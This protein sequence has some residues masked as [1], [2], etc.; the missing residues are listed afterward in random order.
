MQKIACV[1]IALAAAAGAQTFPDGAAYRNI[2]A[3]GSIVPGDAAVFTDPS[4]R[5]VRSQSLTNGNVAGGPSYAT[6]GWV[7]G[8]VAPVAAAVAAETAARAAADDALAE[9][10]AQS[11]AA[12]AAARAAGDADKATTNQLAAAVAGVP[13]GIL[14]LD[15]IGMPPE[16]W[17]AGAVW[18]MAGSSNGMAVVSASLEDLSGRTAYDLWIT[19]AYEGGTVRAR[20]LCRVNTAD[21]SYAHSGESF[22]VDPALIYGEIGAETV[23]V[24]TAVDGKLRITPLNSETPA[25]QISGLYLLVFPGQ[26]YP[27][28]RL[29]LVQGCVS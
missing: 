14:A 5:Y 26:T 13:D 18:A 2:Q 11:L 3:V 27:P 22:I 4:G 10:A 16:T 21:V 28:Y 1:I 17:A 20:R 19:T 23:L 24:V 12:E 6:T 15:D 9:L 25:P 7:A 8:Q 29:I